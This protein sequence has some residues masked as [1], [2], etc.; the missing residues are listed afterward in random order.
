ML[1]TDIQGIYTFTYLVNFHSNGAPEEVQPRL[2]GCWLI[3]TQ[4]GLRCFEW[5]PD[6]ALWY[7]NDDH[8][9]IACSEG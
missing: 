8:F 6:Y 7:C 2:A 9:A 1:E 3:R 5:L 4:R